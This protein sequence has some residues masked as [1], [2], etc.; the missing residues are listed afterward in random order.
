MDNYTLKSDLRQRDIEA[1]FKAR[2]EIE[3][4]CLEVPASQLAGQLAELLQTVRSAGLKPGSSEFLQVFQEFARE[5]RMRQ[6]PAQ[7]SGPEITGVSV[8]AAIRVGWLSGL[9]EGAIG[10]LKPAI[11]RD[12]AQKVDDALG[13]AYELPGE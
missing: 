8:R 4:S 2:R 13:K 11:V 1:F 12:L 10:E 3:A 9:D 5:L 6:A 7:L